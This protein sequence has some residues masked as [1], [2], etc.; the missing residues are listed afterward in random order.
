MSVSDSSIR[1]G[2]KIPRCNLLFTEP[3]LVQMKRS[4]FPPIFCSWRK[5]TDSQRR[6]SRMNNKRLT[7]YIV[8]DGFNNI[9]FG[10]KRTEYRGRS[11]V[12]AVRLHM[13]HDLYE[14]LK[15]E[16]KTQH[17]AHGKL[18]MQRKVPKPVT[19]LS[20][21]QRTILLGRYWWVA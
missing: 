15:L 11:I 12:W 10:I 6:L 3:N 1:D 5:C 21:M 8:D 17:R 19:V 9:P 13:E 7:Y 14:P 2:C 16:K 20:S 18:W 4:I